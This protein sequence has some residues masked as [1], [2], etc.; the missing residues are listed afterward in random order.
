VSLSELGADARKLSSFGSHGE[1]PLDDGWATR[2]G[3]QLANCT[4][5][6][7]A[8]GAFSMASL[9][10][11]FGPGGALESALCVPPRTLVPDRESG[12]RDGALRWSRSRPELARLLASWTDGATTKQR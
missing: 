9:E 10:G 1:D 8:V 6:H 2:R 4:S 11:P 7:G 3:F 12:W 5:C